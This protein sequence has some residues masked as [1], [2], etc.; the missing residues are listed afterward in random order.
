M[1]AISSLTSSRS[2]SHLLMSSCNYCYRPSVSYLFIPGSK[3]ICLTSPFLLIHLSYFSTAFTDEDLIFSA[4][5]F[6]F[7]ILANFIIIIVKFRRLS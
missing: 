3:F 7:S 6:V 2:L 5:H 1:C 4:N